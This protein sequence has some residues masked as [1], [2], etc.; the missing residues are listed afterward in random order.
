MLGVLAIAVLYMGI[1]PK[2]F[3]DV[4]DVSVAGAAQACGTNQAELTGLASERYK[5]I[6]NISWLA[7]TLRSCCWSWPA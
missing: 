1:Y 3:T 2:P 7:F 5:M 6:D 4:M